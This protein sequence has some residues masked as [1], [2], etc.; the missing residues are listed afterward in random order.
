M[1]KLFI[2]FRY[3]RRKKITFFAVAGVAV[4][5]MTLIVVLSVM[6]GFDK[7]LRTKIRGTLAHIIVLKRGIYGLDNYKEVINKIK[8]LEHV[9]ACAPY[10][11]GPAL[12]NIRGAREFAYFK[13]IDPIAEAKVGDFENYIKQFDNKPQD[14][15][16]V[17]GEKKTPS[18]FG[19]IELL[20]I[21]E[22]DPETNPENF[23]KSGEKVVLVTI[24]GWDRINVKPF[25]ITGKFKSGM[26]DVD[27]NYIY[28]PLNI[29]QEL[30]GTKDFVTG[31]SVRLDDYKNAPLVRKRLQKELGFGFYIQT[32]EE[33][34]ETFLKAVALEKR[35]MAFILFFIIIVAGFNIL[36]ILTM[37]VY[38]KSKDIGI[39]K[40]LGA[41]TKGIMLIF[42]LNGLLISLFGSA[43]GTGLGLAFINRIN[44]IE[45]IVYKYSGWRPFPPEVYY[46]NE[47]PTV[48]DF[49]SIIIITSVSIACSILF[50]I[51]PALKAARLDPIE[52][53]RYE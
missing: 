10:I 11:E 7:E 25:I 5:V 33:A 51:Y 41:T 4:G 35:V 18:A 23:V 29:A 6:S 50:S 24:K 52:T 13:G 45:R 2:S 3:L 19:G 44:W 28:I 1:Y 39:L 9:K 16:V 47:I 40:A 53:L 31:I 12:L 34:R 37:I 42:L 48:V 21:G 27:K 15:L 22:G 14:L 46:F 49:K 26:Y 43:I 32:W 36:A 38:E 20:R 17:H 8:S 30:V